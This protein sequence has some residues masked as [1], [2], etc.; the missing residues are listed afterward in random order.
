MLTAFIQD[1]KYALRVMRRSPRDT[2]IAAAILGLGIGANT[3]MFSAVNH[4]LWRPFPFPDEQRLVRLREQIVGNDGN[5][6]P[7]NMSSRAILTVREHATDAFDDVVA[8]RG[9]DMTLLGQELPERVSVV[10]QTSG[11]E[12]TLRVQPVA[13]RALTADE[14][15]LG[16]DAAVALVS[17]AQANT[18]FG[19][20]ARALGQRV[21]LD[22]RTFTIV[23]VMPPQY[24][25][26]YEAQFWI[27]WRLD[28]QDRVRDFA[29]WAHTRAGVTRTQIDDAMTRVAAQMK[30]DPRGDVPGYGIEVRTI[31]DNLLGDQQRP[32]LALTEIVGF[33]LLI[34][35]VNVA[36]LLLARSVARQR[37]FAIRVALG[38][39][40][41]RHISQLVAESLA[42]AGVGC[43]AG[44]LLT[45]W[46][47][48][49]TSALVPTV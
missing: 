46:L 41:A 19:G 3:A 4:V 34:A 39:S 38:Q 40:K 26:P 13:G 47:G 18:R 27:P 43:I 16:I 11:F 45:T 10:L 1:L 37:E 33:M 44:L 21:Q 29:V 24:A 22:D 30:S 48:P 25:F 8:M 32:L 12:H 7:F 17:D 20:A 49:L 42:L 36:T 31:R 14:E 35:A 28:P 5:P 9:E 15:R 23:G 6:H 2:I